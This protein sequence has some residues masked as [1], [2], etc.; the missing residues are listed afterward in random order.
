MI[1]LRRLEKRSSYLLGRGNK[2]RY[3]KIR[4]KEVRNNADQRRYQRLAEI[5]K[6]IKDLSKGIGPKTTAVKIQNDLINLTIPDNDKEM[7]AFLSE[8]NYSAE[9]MDRADLVL[10]YSYVY[11]AKSVHSKLKGRYSKTFTAS[12]A[13][14]LKDDIR[15]TQFS[16]IAKASWDQFFKNEFRSQ[17]FSAQAIGQ[18]L[19]STVN[20]SINLNG[21]ERVRSLEK[22][23]KGKAGMFPSRSLV[24]ANLK[25]FEEGCADIFNPELSDDFTVC[26][27]DPQAV[28]E[29]ILETT[30]KNF[31]INYFNCHQI[32]ANMSSYDTY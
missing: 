16:G 22:N 26:T 28:L 4:N 18:M 31:T 25:D 15:R 32:Y 5:K 10:K 3:I 13:N 6:Q 11:L 21:W 24:Q 20:H 7:I 23:N 14:Q 9:G 29:Q 1:R 30:C 12:L 2:I 27:L 19:D 17:Y 8:H